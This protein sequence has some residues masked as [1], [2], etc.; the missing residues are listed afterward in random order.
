MSRSHS[1]I[2]AG[3]IGLVAPCLS[4]VVASTPAPAGVDCGC[5]TAGENL[6][7]IW[8]GGWNSHNVLR[9]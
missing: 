1:P 9:I 4:L 3:P 7:E 2:A 6:A 8:V 5:S